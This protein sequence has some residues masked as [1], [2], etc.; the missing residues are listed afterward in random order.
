MR[1]KTQPACKMLLESE[2]VKKM[3]SINCVDWTR[4][5]VLCMTDL[6]CS[7]CLGFLSGLRFCCSRCV[8]GLVLREQGGLWPHMWGGGWQ[9]QVLLLS[10]LQTEWNQLVCGSVTCSVHQLIHSDTKASVENAAVLMLYHVWCMWFENW[11]LNHQTQGMRSHAKKFNALSK[12][13]SLHTF[14]DQI[15]LALDKNSRIFY[16][17]WNLVMVFTKAHNKKCLEPNDSL[18]T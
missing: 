4:T 3:L 8:C 6:A 2:M 13:K 1:P 11:G 12:A 7:L 18:L 15:S 10:G 14:L 9:A 16:E 5:P 17:S